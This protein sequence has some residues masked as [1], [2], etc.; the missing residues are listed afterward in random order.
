M[1][2]FLIGIVVGAVFK[3]FFSK[4]WAEIKATETYKALRAK[5]QK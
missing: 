3:P 1:I 2:N 4:V 5:F